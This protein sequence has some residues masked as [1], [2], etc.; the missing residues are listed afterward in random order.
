MCHCVQN[1]SPSCPHAWLELID[2]CYPGRNLDTCPRFQ[3]GALTIVS[4]LPPFRKKWAPPHCC[5]RCNLGGYDGRVTKMIVRE[6][7]GCKLGRSPPRPPP[8]SRRGYGY[9]YGDDYGYDYRDR[10]YGYRE[11]SYGGGCCVL[12]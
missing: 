1:L 7:H 2:P 5:P 11:P 4:R 6:S 10:R 8:R 12:M 9:G 3:D